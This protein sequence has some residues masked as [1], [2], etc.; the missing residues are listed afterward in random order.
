MHNFLTQDEEANEGRCALEHTYKD[1]LFGDGKVQG[2]LGCSY[3]KI[4]SFT[5]FR[6]R[7]K[8]NSRITTWT[9]GE[10][11]FVCSGTCFEEFHGHSPGEEAHNTWLMFVT[12][13]LKLQNGPSLCA[14]NQA[15]VPWMIKERKVTWRGHWSPSF[16]LLKI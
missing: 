7:N 9:S 15:K 11:S 14:R 4:V 6:G 13:L 12:H 8:A 3:H 1:E 5:I 2:S 10:Q 16:E